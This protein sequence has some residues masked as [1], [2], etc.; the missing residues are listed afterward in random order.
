[1]KKIIPTFLMSMSAIIGLAQ[2]QAQPSISVSLEGG[3]SY[4]SSTLQRDALIGNGYQ[5]G[6]DI[7]IPLSGKGRNE[8]AIG[9]PRFTLGV[10]AGGQY[11]SA[12]NINPDKSPLLS[13]Y[14]LP[15]GNL[16][17]T[18]RQNGASNSHGFTAFAG[19]QADLRFGKIAIS[20]SIS[21]GYF[22]LHRDGFT[23]STQVM[24]NGTYQTVVLAASQPQ[25]STGFITIPK[26][27]V[28][29]S[30][31]GNLSIYAAGAINAGPAI[32]TTQSYL[33]PAGGFNEKNTYEA[34][35]LASGKLSLD[36][37]SKDA[38]H[39]T[40]VSMNA[41][42]SWSFGGRSAGRVKGTV[43]KQTQGATF[44]EKVNQGLHA[45]G[46]ALQQ[47]RAIVAGNPIGGIIV[48]GGKN[49]GGG[50]MATTTNDKGAFE[51]T[52]TEDGDYLFT[53]IAPE[54]TGSSPSDSTSQQNGTKKGNP[55]YGD[56]GQSSS[57]PM[58]RNGAFVASPGNPIG[59]IIVKGGKN[60]G[61]STLTIIT[62]SDGTF[63]LNG[64]KAGNY[65]FVI[66]A[67]T[68]P[69]SKSINEKGIK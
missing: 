52:A 44:G 4:S 69:P 45:T 20:P 49:P 1:M 8:P 12:E 53:V 28:S 33:V 47:G 34:Q 22:S 64:I 19:V 61:G 6:G 31:T 60:P 55:L 35:Q 56:G 13:K 38:G 3:R 5:L 46:S 14:R 2:D 43:G 39:F 57:N 37:A 11:L 9:S 25:N 40:A 30:L 15:S 41:G 59:G 24:V 63:R 32:T 18:D 17:I 23:Q 62:N 58:F 54:Q 50:M 67:P 51:F 26:L 7:F 48:K 36:G 29:Y 42:V 27:K 68:E 16:D 21:G 66:T 65:R 10:I